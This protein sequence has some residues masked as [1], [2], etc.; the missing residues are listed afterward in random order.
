MDVTLFLNQLQFVLAGIGIMVAII[1]YII[2]KRRTR[3]SPTLWG[4]WCLI[5]AVY[6]VYRW[7]NVGGALLHASLAS[8][9][10][11]LGVISVIFIGIS[12]IWEVYKHG[13]N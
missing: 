4:M 7:T 2:D 3:Y 13:T 10:F 11:T 12:N 9:I 5:L 1:W 6:R 8:L